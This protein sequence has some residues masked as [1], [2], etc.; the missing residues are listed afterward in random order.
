MDSA[1]DPARSPHEL[2]P[3]RLRHRCD[4]ER[5]EFRTTDDLEDLDQ[6]LGQARAVEA[7]RFGLG[8]KR[9]GYHLFAMG[10]EGSGRHTIVQRFVGERAGAEPVPDDWCYVFD[11]ARPHQ[12]RALRLP[13]G[14]GRS[15]SGAMTRLVD[16]LRA[17]IPAAFETDEYRA[18]R[19]TLEEEFSERQE[20]AIEKVRKHAEELD[21][22]LVRTPTGFAFAPTRAGE[23]IARE[24]FAK[25][26]EEERTSIAQRIETL[27][28][29]L[30]RALLLFPKW[31][32][33]AQQRLR[34]LNRSVTR[35]AVDSL[36]DELKAAYTALPQVV[37]YLGQ[38]QE[39]VLEHAEHF[40][41]R[42]SEPQTLL[43][44]PLRVKDGSESAL[45]RYL[46]NV[47]V[48]HGA[49]RGAP[50]VYEDQP[51][52]DN[53]VGRIDHVAQMGALVT[54][55]TMVKS[56]ALHRANG[57]YLILDLRKLLV[58][59]FSW[60]ALKRALRAGVI[61]TESLGQAIGLVSTMA[62]KPEPIPL[63]LKVVL[64]GERLLYYLLHAYDPDFAQLFKV[65]VDF[66]AEMERRPESDALYARLVATIVRRE[67]LRAFDRA[68]VARVVDH[69]VRLAGDAAR[70][71]ILVGT[72]ADLLRESDHWAAS[73]GH[74]RVGATDVQRA[75]D[76]QERRADRVR[77]H[78]RE[79]VQRGTILIDTGGAK[80]GQVNGLSVLQLGGYAFG[81]P[82]RITAR[83]RLGSGQVLDIE[84]EVELGG[85]V[86]AK[87][88]LILTGFLA[89]RFAR[90]QPLALAASLVF[91][92]SYAGVE[93]DSASLAELCAL[94]SALAELPVQQG[95]AVTGSVNQLG[96]VQAVGGVNEKIEGFFA[97][98]RD[99]GLNG[100][101]GVL[102]P[103]A[104][105]Q[106][107]M[108]HE[109][110]VQAV[111]ERRFHVH[112]VAHVDEAV[113]LLT[114]IAAGAP[115]PKGIWPEAS[116]N[117]RVADRLAA[118]AA[119][120]RRF[121]AAGEDDTERKP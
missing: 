11:F 64:V 57:G 25:L 21:I 110:V 108:L 2:A 65:V 80:V 59:P 38:V 23:T 73:G 102:I 44:L 54:D 74:A 37:E 18:R 56:G 120:A 9:T 20:E 5:Y 71:S 107:L 97:V 88:V 118:F 87:G 4:P 17:A 14:Q 12:P 104:N 63:D 10:P 72:L 95:L 6:V 22:A 1:K 35:M 15:F 90:E 121:R 29:E 112:A 119:A 93:G 68:A 83:V 48:D 24:E 77:Q 40:H 78:L 84:R 113:A 8:I 105:V 39:D 115:D 70:L 58:Q 3:E 32:R 41:A 61:C 19:Q 13:P 101:Q 36:I 46:V 53:L 114:G 66:D 94:L 79:E 117:R 34:E 51:T 42:D 16:E 111:A 82:S 30:Q 26:P 47:L 103:K 86:H 89:G 99:R 116:V 98:C 7:L 43:G 91:E 92:Q 62:M 75:I 45:Q 100:E 31:R 33:E 49:S 50:V 69:A 52:Y 76:A 28:G 27:E 67:K 109:D 55:F 85:P 96:E 81:H 106:H 60:E